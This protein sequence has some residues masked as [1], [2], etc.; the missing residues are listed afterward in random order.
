MSLISRLKNGLVRK[1]FRD[2]A[3]MGRPVPKEVFD[4]EYRAGHWDLLEGMEELPRNLVLSGLVTRMFDRPSVLDVGCGNCRLIELLKAHPMARCMGVDVSSEGIQRAGSRGL[5]GVEL[6]EADF[7]TWRPADRFDAIIFNESIGYAS[8]P[9]ATLVDFSAHLSSG[10]GMF[11][12]SYFRSGNHS[13]LWRRIERVCE[14]VFATSIVSD[15]K[16]V[17]DIKVLRPRNVSP[18]PA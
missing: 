10:K 13:A 8:D 14:P 12:L 2:A 11:F 16:R 3:G 17:W 5:T 15:T 7:E 6:V 9:A 1:L 4:R 18:G